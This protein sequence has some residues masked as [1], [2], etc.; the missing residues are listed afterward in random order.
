[1]YQRRLTSSRLRYII[2]QHSCF[3]SPP[4]DAVIQLS[5]ARHLVDSVCH[6]TAGGAKCCGGEGDGVGIFHHLGRAEL[7]FHRCR[8]SVTRISGHSD[9]FLTSSQ[10]RPE[11]TSKER[12]EGKQL[13]CGEK[14]QGEVNDCAEIV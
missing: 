8:P 12:R 1:M 2:L 10:A 3:S 7:S 6:E 14:V 9:Y 4:I 13:G 5:Q 11:W